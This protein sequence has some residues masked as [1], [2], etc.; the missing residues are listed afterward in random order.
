MK[1]RICDMIGIEYP[2][3]QGGMAW[4]AN[5]ALASAVSNAGG[6][7]IVACGH[8]PGDVVKGFIEEMERFNRQT[9]WCKYYAI[10]SI[11]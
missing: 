3:I 1:S 7:G 9:I 10:K 5:P 6:L 8:A 2:I 11:C 4:V